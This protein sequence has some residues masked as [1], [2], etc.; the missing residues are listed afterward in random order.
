MN[1]R[2][3][4]YDPEREAMILSAV[5]WR[6][7]HADVLLS[8]FTSE[9]FFSDRH[10]RIFEVC[11]MLRAANREVTEDAVRLK[12]I[13]LDWWH[14]IGNVVGSSFNALSA[15]LNAPGSA[16]PIEVTT[17]KLHNLTRQRRLIGV[18]ARQLDAA[19]V[20][21]DVD[22]LAEATE[23]ALFQANQGHVSV[24]SKMF[25]ELIDEEVVRLEAIRCGHVLPQGLP[26]GLTLL[27]KFLKGLHLG[28]T[29]VIAG[30]PGMGKSVIGVDVGRA[31]AKSDHGGVLCGVL[32]FAL[33]MKGR[34]LI[35]RALAS[36][37]RVEARKLESHMATPQERE[38]HYE[39]AKR[40]YPLP[41][42]VD[43]TTGVDPSYVR[44]QIRRH[45]AMFNT[46]KGPSGKPQRLSVVVVDYLQRMKS[47]SHRREKREEVAENINE[48]ADIGKSL[49]VHMVVLSQLSREGTKGPGGV[50][51]PRMS[52]LAESGEIERAADNIALLHREEYYE[53]DKS[54]VPTHMQGKAEIIIEKQREGRQGIVLVSFDGKSTTFVDASD[55]DFEKW[56]YAPANQPRKAYA[57]G[58][59]FRRDAA[60]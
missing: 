27:D 54:C 47:K 15:V 56:S 31:V 26:T 52:D 43:E 13:D 7:A 49:G 41:I 30:R 32:M 59:K 58:S 53:Q 21:K 39:A 42:F 60:E 36:E 16:E 57:P 1:D 33:E 38:R 19:Y 9:D 11:V 46:E 12:L 51:R 5:A 14:A 29:T 20:S 48:L 22:A 6:P 18:L 10:R 4:P 23:H 17:K 35:R 2:Q 3:L 24:G 40:L 34:S 8:S 45:Q 28:E 50:R 37:S 25:C 55:A 44:A